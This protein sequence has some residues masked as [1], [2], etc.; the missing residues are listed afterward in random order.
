MQEEARAKVTALPSEQGGVNF[1][2]YWRTD[3]KI[4]EG[5]S[6]SR[7]NELAGCS[8]KKKRKRR[9]FGAP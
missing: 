3:L 4:F 8:K 1:S 5:F 6:S 2:Y 9:R 7:T